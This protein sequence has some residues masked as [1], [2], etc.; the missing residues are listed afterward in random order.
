MAAKF[1][2]GGPQAVSNVEFKTELFN[3]QILVD[4][5]PATFDLARDVKLRVTQMERMHADGVRYSDRVGQ[6]GTD[7]ILTPPDLNTTAANGV[8]LGQALEALLDIY[9]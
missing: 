7:V 2:R 9:G 1:P 5:E 6:I 3:L 8:T 4:N